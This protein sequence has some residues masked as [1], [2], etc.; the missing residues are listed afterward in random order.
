MAA[1]RN[2]FVKLFCFLMLYINCVRCYDPKFKSHLLDIKRVSYEIFSKNN[3]NIS[4]VII[5]TISQHN[6]TENRECL[7]ELT[8]IKNGIDNFEEWAFVSM[9]KWKKYTSIR[10]LIWFE[11]ISPVLDSWGKF[12]SGM[13]SGNFFDFGAFSQ[14]FHIKHNGINY[15]TQYCIGQFKFPPTKRSSLLPRLVVEVFWSER[16]SFN[17]QK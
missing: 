6:W 13:M 3:F 9:W 15:K 8:A 7:V 2:Y 14:C 16:I 1:F 4:S 10:N 11:I 12:P 17:F 5:E